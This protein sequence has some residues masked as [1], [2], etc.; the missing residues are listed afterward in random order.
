MAAPRPRTSSELLIRLAVRR[1]SSRH[2]CARKFRAGRKSCRMP[3]SKLREF[4][5]VGVRHVTRWL[6]ALLAVAG[7]AAPVHAQIFPSK[8][9][10]IIVPYAPGGSIDLT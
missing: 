10:R 2:F 8:T 5:D 9:I 1:T 7:L 3:R 6:I 4:V